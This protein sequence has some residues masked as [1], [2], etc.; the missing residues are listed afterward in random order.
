[1]TKA[2]TPDIGDLKADTRMSRLIVTDTPEALREIAELIRAL[3][4][5]PREVL[6][7]AKM[8]QI[9][10]RDIFS[11]GVDWESVFSSQSKFKGL[12]LIG[13]F[14]ILP[15]PSRAIKMTVGELA[16]DNY[17]ATI[18]ALREFGNTKL[19]SSPRLITLS[20]KEAL[21]MVGKREAYA[22]TTVTQ[23]EAAATT[24]ESIQF[25]DVGITLR[26]TPVINE[27]RF[28]VMKIEPEISDVIRWE[29]TAQGNRVPIVQT[30]NAQTNVMVKDGVTIVIAGLIKDEIEDTSVGV[31]V[32]S[33]IPLIG[34]LFRY[35]T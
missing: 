28:I 26:V 22:T 21:F 19:I 2:L 5:R 9:V 30:S 10:L 27:E 3:D 29:T 18:E 35:A 12:G 8:I 33:Q 11:M 14:P 4:A 24:A 6:I 23:T 16:T 13:D 25:V 34:G 7:E 1:V 32:L 15:I 17:T 31:P 20:G